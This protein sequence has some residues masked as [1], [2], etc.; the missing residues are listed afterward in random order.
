M[1]AFLHPESMSVND[2]VVT[3]VDVANRCA[4][5]GELPDSEVVVMAP[6]DSWSSDIG[7]KIADVDWY[8]E[9]EEHVAT[10]ARSVQDRI[11][12]Q[13]AVEATRTLTFD[14]FARYFQQFL[15]ALPPFSTLAV[16]KRPVAFHV[17]S[18]PEPYWIVDFKHRR[19]IRACEL[20][21]DV[22]SV[23][24]VADGVLAD[25]ID[26]RLVNFIH[27]SMRLRT[28][29]APGG[30]SDDLAFW[31]LLAIWEIGYLPAR[32]LLNRRFLDVLWRRRREAVDIAAALR[33]RGSVLTRMST[34][35][36]PPR[37]EAGGVDSGTR[38][39]TTSATDIRGAMQ[40]AAARERYAKDVEEVG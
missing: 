24:T 16:L 10:L 2:A 8:T 7:F 5:T 3:P 21:A 38:T 39:E 31:G 19:V 18:D 11:D 6:G 20:P 1:V 34:T 14:A 35:F 12:A 27:I 25:A 36:T 22:A 30:T 26:K 37:D 32:R 23:I 17:A 28:R 15:D 40:S 13:T 9:R 29:V 4:K 33:G